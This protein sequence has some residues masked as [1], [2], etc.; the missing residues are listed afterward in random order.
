MRFY[1]KFIPLKKLPII[2]QDEISECGIACI[3][4]IANYYG[5]DI[6]LAA[7]RTLHRPSLKGTSLLDLIKLCELLDL[8]AKVLRIELSDLKKIQCPAILYWDLNHFVVLKKIKKNKFIIHDPAIGLQSC[9]YQKFSESFTGI[10]IEVQ[11]TNNFKSLKNKTHISF[12]SILKNIYGIGS[13]LVLLF[14]FSIIIEFLGLVS[15]MFAQYITDYGIENKDFNNILILASAFAALALIQMIV[16]FIRSKFILQIKNNLTEQFSSNTFLHILKLP[17]EFFEKRHKGDIQTRF[18]AIEYLQNKLSIDFIN[19]FLD[20]LLVIF[21]FTVMFMYNKLLTFVV[22]ISS[23]F[24]ITI[25]FL[26][27]KYSKR[28]TEEALS[29]QSNSAT[30]FLETLQSMLPVKAF[31]KENCRFNLWHNQYLQYLNCDFKLSKINI[32]CSTLINFLQN[33]DYIILLCISSLLIIK[34]SFSIGMLIAFLAYRNLL[35]NKIKA[36]LQNIFDYKIISIHLSRL[37]DILF[38][39]P[40]EIH[41]K[42]NNLENFEYLSLNNISFT[43][44]KKSIIENFNLLIRKGEKIVIT[45]PSGCGKT[46][47]LKIM[48][49]LLQPRNGSILINTTELSQFGIKN[50]RN[51]IASVMQED[52]LMRGSVLENI[53]FFD[54]KIDM[55]K[56]L[57]ATRMACIHEEIMNMPM[58][59]DTLVGDMG[60]VFSGGQKQRIL[61]ARAL[62]RQ[63]KILFLDEATSHLDTKNE[64]TINQELKTLSITQI[65]VAH[66]KET[67]KLADRVVNLENYITQ[68]KEKV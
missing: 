41:A 68:I 11:K 47:L 37:K 28:Y 65:I 32:T 55:E 17:L 18:N 61:L 3:N 27:Y 23:L 21:T 52:T 48:M 14:G 59:Y 51:N 10:V 4:M 58:G 20:S 44:E 13:T 53:S 15:P 8:R 26:S 67:I 46:T 56:I 64:Q 16:E 34:N 19:T 2:L 7:L 42:N 1:S 12:L 40:E 24:Y 29:A 33:F 45:G 31:G 49:G 25:T 60:S 62:Y 9:S 38:H 5:H 54:N 50:Y 66:R 22:T 57:L 63:P 39:E 6:D 35:T 36:L 43:Y 30:S